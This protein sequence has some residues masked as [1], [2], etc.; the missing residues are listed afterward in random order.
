MVVDCENLDFF[1]PQMVNS[2]S[3]SQI[4]EIIME[5][6]SSADNCILDIK[7]ELP[8]ITIDESINKITGERHR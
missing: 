3:V 5:Y 8:M 4:D 1:D 7:E 2:L 6:Y